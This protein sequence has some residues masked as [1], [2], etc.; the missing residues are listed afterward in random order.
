MQYHLHII[1]LFQIFNSYIEV[2]VDDSGGGSSGV[3]M[4]RASDGT[5]HASGLMNG[6]I[7]DSQASLDS[8][9]GGMDC[10]VEELKRVKDAIARVRAVTPP[11]PSM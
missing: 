6:H 2:E 8:P 1:Y 3:P 10:T 9:M 5:I 7:S 11:L 4:F